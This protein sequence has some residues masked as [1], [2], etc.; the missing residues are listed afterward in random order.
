MPRG[1]MIGLNDAVVRRIKELC[2]QK[3][4]SAY[5]LGV[6]AG[7]SS[8]YVRTVIGG[9]HQQVSVQT[10]KKICDACEITLATFFSAAYFEHLP[11]E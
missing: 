6:E 7:L 11:M 9:K 5:R 1:V 3:G 2:K 8:Q 10:I 4:W